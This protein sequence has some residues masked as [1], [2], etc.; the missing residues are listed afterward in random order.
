MHDN[1]KKH[2][3]PF[4]PKY[5]LTLFIPLILGK[6]LIRILNSLEPRHDF[7]SF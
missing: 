4:L 7:E 5:H 2:G 6:Y 1:S 3:G